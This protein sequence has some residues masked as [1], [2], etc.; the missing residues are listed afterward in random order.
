MSVRKIFLLPDVLTHYENL[1]WNLPSDQ[2]IDRL[3]CE[4]HFLNRER[5]QNN[6]F[7]L[8][9]NFEKCRAYFQSKNNN[10]VVVQKTLDQLC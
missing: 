8:I 9:N 1:G 5:V 6:L 7:K 2:Q 3:L 4:E 10:S